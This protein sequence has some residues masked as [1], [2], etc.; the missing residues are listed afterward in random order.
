MRS[1]VGDWNND[2]WYVRDDTYHQKLLLEVEPKVQG[3]VGVI[4]IH[5]SQ[6]ASLKPSP[7]PP[8]DF[9]LAEHS[10]AKTNLHLTQDRRITSLTLHWMLCFIAVTSLTSAASAF[11]FPARQIN[12]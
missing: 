6:F 5:G 2:L 1:S 10:K 7:R 12:T 9:K 4:R 3:P 11:N 8:L